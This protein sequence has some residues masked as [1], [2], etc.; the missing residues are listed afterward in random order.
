M[1]TWWLMDPVPATR[2]PQEPTPPIGPVAPLSTVS[3][4]ETLYPSPAE[5]LRAVRDDYLYWTGKLSDT[6]LQLSYAVIAANWAAFG[7][8]NGVLA[9]IWS[10][11]SVGL[12]IVALGLSVVGAKWMGESLRRRIEYAETDTSRWKAE[13]EDNAGKGNPW[14][15]T[16]AID[17]LGRGMREARTWL[18][19]VAGLLFVI[20][21]VRR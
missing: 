8:V 19:L 5:A 6:S 15:F 16:G 7:S 17:S 2:A 18:P 21:L 1:E 13:F 20:A 10:K 4:T 14:P 9:S 3:A 11:F 12:V